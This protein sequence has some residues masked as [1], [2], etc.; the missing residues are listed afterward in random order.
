MS[1]S[2][3]PT[4]RM[5]TAAAVAVAALALAACGA[6]EQDV[7]TSPAA[8]G[9]STSDSAAGIE[10]AKADIDKLS[11]NPTWP[12]FDPLST[13]PDIKGKRF[14]YIPLGAQAAVMNGIGVGVTRALEAA[15]ASVTTCDGK[16]NPTQVATCLKTA[17][18]EGVDGVITAFVD[19]Q[20]AA[21]AFDALAAKGTKVI[22]GGVAPSGGRTADATLAFF[23]NTPRV[24]TMQE[25]FSEA[26]LADQGTDAK[27][28]WAKLMDSTTTQEASDKGM[29]K[30]TEL[31]PSCTVT[32]VE[33]STVNI[34]K[35][36]SAVSAALVANPDTTAL[37]VP[38]DTFV[39]PA[40]GGV[41]SSGKSDQVKI[42]SGSG[43]LEGLQRVAAGQQASDLGTPVLFE[44]WR[45]THAMMQLLAGDQVTEGTEFISRNFTKDSVGDLEL[46]PEK[47]LSDDWYGGSG[48]QDKFLTS[49]G[50]K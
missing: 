7:S 19:Y 22:I 44:G 23:D 29:A 48:Y 12:D 27:L 30:F 20:M 4:R 32:S 6:G 15:G 8:S 47:Y 50:L 14:T 17:G 25:H 24:D 39:A 16:F 42:Y 13:T 9:A 46:T 43:D 28:L 18:D 35:L 2:P 37:V 45:F 41:Q 34:D 36:S 40:L 26:V 33:F 49:W 31:C 11:G 10:Q 3:R 21:P 1:S 5:S 38:V